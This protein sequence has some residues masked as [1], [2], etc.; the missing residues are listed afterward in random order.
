[1]ARLVSSR[2]G[3]GKRSLLLLLAA[4]GAL[5]G[6]AYLFIGAG[7][8]EALERRELEPDSRTA[9]GALAAAEEAPELTLD[10]ATS[11]SR[12]GGGRDAAFNGVRLAG[13]GKLT[14]VVLD[15]ESGAGVAG[16][17]VELL[18][19]PP[20]GSAFL[21]RALQLARLG[22]DF[23]RRARPA[24]VTT[25]DSLGSFAFEGVREGR[26]YV[27]ITSEYFLLEAPQR[28]DVLASGEGGPE[29]VWV[30]EGGRVLGQVLDP[31]GTP[32]AG[33]TVLLTAGPNLFLESARE[34]TLRVVETRADESGRFAFGGVAAGDGYDLTATAPQ[35]ASSHL[36]EVNVR[37]GED[38]QVVL[39]ARAGGTVVG[40]VFSARVE[41]DGDERGRLPLAGA[42]VGAIPRGLRDLRFLR[43]VLEET[44]CETDE[45]GAYR[46]THVPPGDVDIV[47]FAPDH[48]LGAGALVVVAEGEVTSAAPITM[49][50]GEVLFGRVL[51]AQGAP[52]A[53]V[54][55]TWPT[56]D[57]R[58]MRRRGMDLTFAPFLVQAVEGFVFPKTDSEGRFRAGPFPGEPPHRIRLYKPGYQEVEVEGTP[59]GEE[60]EVVLRR[61]GA[62]EGLVMDLDEAVPVERFS[63]QTIDR[64]ETT[65]DAPG[66]F[67]PFSGGQTFE[68]PSGRFVLDSMRPGDVE[69]TVSA[70]GFMPRRV[71]GVTV[72]EGETKRGVIVTL[73]RGGVLRGVVVDQAGE[74][75]AGAAVMA[76]DPSIERGRE[77]RQQRDPSKLPDRLPRFSEGLPPALLGYAA[78]LGLLADD[79]VRSG[80]DGTFELT[81]VP[82]G[83]LSVVAFHPDHASGSSE[84]FVLE[85][86]GSI[87]GLRIELSSGAAVYGTVKDRHGRPMPASMVVAMSPSRFAGSDASSVGGGLYQTQTDL[88]GAYELKNM[89]SGSFFIMSMR[90]DEALNPLSFFSTLDFDLVT[91]PADERV[92]F[93]IVDESFGGTRVFGRVLDDGQPVPRGNINAISWEGENVLGVDWKLARIDSEG[94]YEFEGL[95]P[96]E[97]QF[98]LEGL[99]RR[100][101]MTVDIPDVPEH[102]LDLE[103]PRG[104]VE[105]RVVDDVTGEPVVRARVF[106]RPRDQ[107]ESD[108]L[109]A[110]LVRQGGELYRERTDGDGGFVF[111]GLSEGDFELYVDPSDSRS[112]R[113]LAPSEASDV[114]LARD[115]VLA[116][117]EVRLRTAAKLSGVVVDDSGVPVEGA[118]ISCMRSDEPDLKPKRA[119]SGADGVFRVTGISAG[120][121]SLV[122]SAPGYANSRLD[123]LQVDG[124]ESEEVELVLER[125]VE[126]LLDL[127]A[128]DG[129]PLSGAS[130]RLVRTDA[131]D[132]GSE[133]PTSAVRALFSGQGTTDARG[134]LELGRYQ[135]GTYELSVWRGLSRKRVPGLELGKDDT[136][137]LRVTLD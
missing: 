20:V 133:D 43:E 79:A 2:S 34:G 129:S 116:G 73:V 137:R 115:E 95:A 85:E 74:P 87:D 37:R 53:G 47:V 125:G 121:H 63:I 99:N 136:V 46:M 7:S 102:R 55:V 107:V 16:A 114:S 51:D 76:F 8:G 31:E 24:A 11:E 28:V 97:Y 96:G 48:V 83:K 64:V 110:S 68:D 103:L 132:A 105:G 54:D 100:V 128:A 71:S 112:E 75:I 101:R 117:L 59:G 119:R 134:E 21:G 118:S 52:I 111:K 27:D 88:E 80:R 19:M 127:S 12:G 94:L 90:G 60:L 131:P 15:R 120:E 41:E 30:R 77:F 113:S 3:A 45:D 29:E 26:Y 56:F 1:M 38:T 91:I 98:T 9:P 84:E 18:P 135:R 33:A 49:E 5:C 72:V 93:D 22:D 25:A 81:S 82:S 65:A 4:L 62:V 86:G 57:F 69:F 35:I 130:A 13:D 32:L 124:L 61:G 122:V 78:G 67:N 40:R 17:R 39:R 89:S 104:R 6:G 70:P 44:H 50:S 126:V 14:G 23:V 123:G 66:R 58:S 92:R 109:L 42:H 108:S 36:T 106:L 10:L